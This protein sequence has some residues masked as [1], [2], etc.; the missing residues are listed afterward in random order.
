M[1]SRP[2]AVVRSR[3]DAEA[4]GEAFCAVG[5]D[6]ALWLAITVEVDGK[7]LFESVVKGRDAGD[8][9]EEAE[10]E[11]E[12]EG[13]FKPEV[14]GRARDAVRRVRADAGGGGGGRVVIVFLFVQLRMNRR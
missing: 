11:E 1:F 8:P 13:P 10:D 14:L 7:V 6:K 4:E 5:G 2:E 9:V 3:G 12:E